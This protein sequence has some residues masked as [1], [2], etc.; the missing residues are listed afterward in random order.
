MKPNYYQKALCQIEN[1]DT[2]YTKISHGARANVANTLILIKWYTTAN[3]SGYQ[4]IHECLYHKTYKTGH[5]LCCVGETRWHRS[6]Y[7]TKLWNK[8]L[9]WCILPQFTPMMKRPRKRNSYN[10]NNL[11]HPISTAP[12]I[13]SKLL[14]SNPPFL[15]RKRKI[16]NMAQNNS[17]LCKE[18]SFP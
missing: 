4:A 8:A 17:D 1:G 14:R 3:G 11:V 2:Q 7:I 12:T 18:S 5:L 13:P 10:W 15:K 6:A 9:I 16:E